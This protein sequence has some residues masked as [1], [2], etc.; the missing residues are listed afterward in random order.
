VIHEC[1]AKLTRYREALKAGTDPT[2]VARWT[3]E[4]QAR[5]AEALARSRQSTGRRRMS[6][7]EI[8]SLV[9]AIGNIH[10][11]L[12]DAAPEDKAQVYHQL[13]LHLSYEPAKRGL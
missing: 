1:D 7:D 6:K 10:A 2:L 9:E 11:V 8:R 4:I 13:G 3:T 5:R 12:A